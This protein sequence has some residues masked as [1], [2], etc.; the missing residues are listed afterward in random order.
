MQAVSK[1]KYKYS[2][3][4][5]AI[6]KTAVCLSAVVILCKI[7]G[8][9]E[10]IIVANFFGTDDK[11]D[12]YFASMTIILSLFFL[13]KELVYPAVLP[14]FAKALKI[15][16][17]ASSA[18]F[19]KLFWGLFTALI[20]IL[21]GLVTF[22]DAVSSVLVPGFSTQ[23]QELTSS[24]LKLLAP[25][26]LF[27]G[28]STLTYSV[29]NCRKNFFKA[30][31]PQAGFKLLIAA[32]LLSLLPVIGLN[33]VGITFTIAACCLFISQLSLIPEK[34]GLFNSAEPD[35]N[36]DTNKVLK[37]MAPLAIGVFFSHISGLVD[38]ALAST[39]AT[40]DLSCLGY[41]KKLTDAVV[42]IG[43]VALVTVVYSQ[44]SHLALQPGL[45]EFKK[46]FTKTI[47]LI[48]FL[49]IPC[50]VL[51]VILRVPIV[52]V[53]FERGRFTTAST[54]GTSKAFLIYAF[55]VVTFSI[56]SVIVYSFYALS[57]TKTPVLAGVFGV[58][59]DIA[60]ALCFV[61]PFGLAAIA[62]AFVISKT[63][64]VAALTFIMERKLCFV[65]KTKILNFATKVF[66]ISFV[67]AAAVY[68][69]NYLLERVNSGGKFI[70]DLL[71]PACIFIAMFIT[72]SYLL[73]LNELKDVCEIVFKK[74]TAK[75]IL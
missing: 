73:K 74:K 67:S 27:L 44:L 2:N 28:M 20:I 30:A 50:A 31:L 25:G 57:N 72:A 13:V 71:I 18:L 24:V 14:V 37:L 54:A 15:S 5:T 10:K 53:L 56:E 12:V 21:I 16:P 4:T 52:E 75:K 7:L 17:K 64:K 59:L 40:G 69:I 62:W 41:A 9:A 8:F 29:L 22:S 68:P 34:N 49:S 23:K 6:G 36:C 42:L 35:A 55:G 38:N 45:S 61:K 46:L 43:P 32:G 26:C 58:L 33:A 19:K 1:Q 48:I 66:G 63:V 11:A 3:T 47:R 65:R 39:L 70:F 60:L 51:L